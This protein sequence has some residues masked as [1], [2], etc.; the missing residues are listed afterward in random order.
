MCDRWKKASGGSRQYITIRTDRSILH[1]GLSA[2]VL[3][4]W[5]EQIV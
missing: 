5:F 2:T 4:D 3:Y 1:F